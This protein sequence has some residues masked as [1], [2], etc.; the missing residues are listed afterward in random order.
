MLHDHLSQ[1][2]IMILIKLSSSVFLM[3]VT[4]L[5]SLFQNRKLLVV[6]FSRVG[7]DP[8]KPLIWLK[9]DIKLSLMISF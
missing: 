3:H 4:F 5:N 1:M 6:L 8:L 7:N 2:K 9:I